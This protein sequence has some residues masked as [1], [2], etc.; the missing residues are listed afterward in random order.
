MTATTPTKP[1]I[2]QSEETDIAFLGKLAERNGVI[3]YARGA[4]LHFGPRNNTASAEI[5][6]PWGGGLITF[7]PEANLARQISV[8]EVVGTSAVNGEQIVGRAQ[9]GQETGRDGGGESGGERQ[10]EALSSEPVYRVRAA[11]HTQQ[12]ADA[13]ARA[14][15][16]ERAMF[17][18]S[19]TAE[20][21]G[22]PELRPDMNVAFEGLGRGFSKTYW[23]SA[24]VH[25]ISGAGFTTSIT[26]Q[27]PTI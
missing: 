19:G 25:E 11:V 26:V 12:E 8:V 7:S 4:T 6:L 27:E 24:A 23:V 22:L 16:E 3:F 20:C 15:L 10:A 13:R 9:K 2:D 18:V 14:I 5:V 21:I 1:R 17:F